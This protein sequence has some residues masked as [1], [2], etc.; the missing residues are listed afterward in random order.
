MDNFNLQKFLKQGKLIT[1]STNSNDY[2]PYEEKVLEIILKYVEDP[3]DA[4]N[5]L[6]LHSLHGLA[7]VTDELEANL[8]RDEE[9]QQLTNTS[10]ESESDSSSKEDEIE[11]SSK[12]TSKEDKLRK[13]IRNEIT[14]ILKEADEEE[15]I[16]AEVEDILADEGDGEEVEVDMEMNAGG[17][18]DPDVEEIQDLLTQA[19]AKASNLDDKKL[20]NQIGNTITYFTRAHV[21]KSDQTG[22]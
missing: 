14:S 1:E 10:K 20:L 19:Q 17:E 11:E 18:V 21:V 9:Y 7:G 6:V 8:Q 12:D 4:E 5:Q 13:A 2:T 22:I 16:D 15:D 3:D